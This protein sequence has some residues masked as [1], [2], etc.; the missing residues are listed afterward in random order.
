LAAVWELLGATAV[1]A[2]ITK[3]EWGTRNK[4]IALDL[5]RRDVSPEQCVVAWRSATERLGEPVRTMKLV[6]DELMRL[7]V[8]RVH[9]GGRPPRDND[10]GDTW[11]DAGSKGAA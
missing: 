7:A 5:A 11:E 9:R 3:T 8:P 2:T 10:R 4:R 6:Q 1:S